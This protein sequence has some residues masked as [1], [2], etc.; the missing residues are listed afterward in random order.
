MASKAQGTKKASR[1][2]WISAF[3][4]FVEVTQFLVFSLMAVPRVQVGC[5]WCDPALV[6]ILLNVGHMHF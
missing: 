3:K 1:F 2:C 4:A 6:H 5:I